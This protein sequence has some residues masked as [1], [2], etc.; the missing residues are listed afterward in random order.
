MKSKLIIVALLAFA[1]GGTCPSDVNNDGTV[2]IT[3]FLQL[4][5]DWGPCP[6]ARVVAVSGSSSVVVRIWSDNTLQLSAADAC[7]GCDES[8]PRAGV[9]T[10]VPP[11]PFPALAHPADVGIIDVPSQTF[12]V[13][14]AYSDGTTYSR[15]YTSSQNPGCAPDGNPGTHCF[16][17]WQGDW[18][19]FAP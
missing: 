17:L 7:F 18:Q 6:A 8:F 1:A 12:V 9:W 3:D 2:G 5:G 10:D 16:I 15:N 11:P 13:V 14:V 19:L 4:L